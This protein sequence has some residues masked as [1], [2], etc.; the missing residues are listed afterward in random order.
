[1]ALFFKLQWNTILRDRYFS[2]RKERS[3]FIEW[4]FHL[5]SIDWKTWQGQKRIGVSYKKNSIWTEKQW[6]NL[7]LTAQ[8]VEERRRE[9]GKCLFKEGSVLVLFPSLFSTS[10]SKQRGYILRKP[11][12]SELIAFFP[13][14]SLEVCKLHNEVLHPY[15]QPGAIPNMW[16]WWNVAQGRFLVKWVWGRFHGSWDTKWCASDSEVHEC[17]SLGRIIYEPRGSMNCKLKSRHTSHLPSELKRFPALWLKVYL[18]LV[19]PSEVPVQWKN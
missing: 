1:M 12:T 5:R 15:I 9:K 17:S 3:K 10:P 8:W 4:L 13:E 16:W 7:P 2:D 6:D 14:N 18:R 11:R 19:L